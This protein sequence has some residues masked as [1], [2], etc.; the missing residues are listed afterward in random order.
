[1]PLIHRIP[2]RPPR[3]LADAFV[4]SRKIRLKPTRATWLQNRPSR[5]RSNGAS[6]VLS[7]G[8][9][10]LAWKPLYMVNLTLNMNFWGQIYHV[11]WFYGQKVE[12]LQKHEL[13]LTANRAEPENQPEPWPC[14][15][16]NFKILF[17]KIKPNTLLV[18]HV[19]GQ[20]A[21][22]TYVRAK[23]CIKCYTNRVTPC[24]Y[25][26]QPILDISRAAT[27]EYI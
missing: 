19:K 15:K 27:K 12:Y 21:A 24:R 18:Q 16:K 1:M 4:L 2:T 9:H 14:P 10:F 17:Q 7:V 6:W 11:K 20:R 3:R 22:S 8:I 25:S 5:N 26:E 23:G 13:E